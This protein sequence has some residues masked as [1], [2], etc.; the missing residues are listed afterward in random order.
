VKPAARIAGTQGYAEQADELV[1]RYESIPFA[2]KHR[3]VLHLIPGVPSSVLDIGAGTGADAAWL[4]DRG[5]RVVAVEPTEALRVPG[6]A[7]HASAP[8]EW[9][10]DSLPQLMITLARGETFDVVMMTAVWMH[11]DEA[12]RCQ[13][14]PRV[15]SLIRRGGV[16]FMSLRHGPPSPGRRMF[17]VPAEETV[18]LAHA[19]GLRSI[20]TARTQSVQP[21]NRHAGVTWSHLAFERVRGTG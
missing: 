11:L 13:A 1:K 8:I 20:L 9:I 4:A 19:H 14:M 7:L 12:E 2:D 6:I 3:P 10:D 17:D 18:R 5:H 21:G 16:L 15:A